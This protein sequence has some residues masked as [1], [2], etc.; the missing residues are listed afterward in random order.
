MRAFVSCT[1]LAMTAMTGLGCERGPHGVTMEHAAIPGRT[2]RVA[3]AS[4]PLRVSAANPR[5]FADGS[6]RVIYLTGS[7]TWSNLQDIG[8]TD[9]PPPFDFSRH[10]D[11]LVDHNHNFTRLWVWE[12]ARWS[13]STA[14]DIYFR[15]L[16][17]ARTGPGTA[18]DG[19]AKFDLTR[20]EPSY[21]DRLRDRVIA[22]GAR[23]IYVSVMLF[24]GWS[25]E[26]KA[27]PGNPWLGHPYHADNNVNGVDLDLDGNGTGEELHTLRHPKA[28]ALQEAYVR[29]VVDTLHDLDNVLWEISNESPPNSREWQHHMVEVIRRHEAGRPKQHPIGVTPMDWTTN[30]LVFSSPSAWVSPVAAD[31]YKDDPPAASGHKVVISDTDHL[32]GMG[33]DGT[34]V[35]KTF[36]RGLNPIYMDD[37]GE[38]TSKAAK[39]DAR[40]AMGDTLAYANRIDLGAMVPR[41]DLVS[42]TYCLANPGV[43][44]LVYVPVDRPLPAVR[45]LW[46]LRGLWT[47]VRG[48]FRQTV[49]VDLTAVQGSV[50]VEWFDPAARRVTRGE[51]VSGGARRSFTAPF[52]G[53]A[54]LYLRSER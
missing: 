35:W 9:P 40:R 4:G 32:W 19:G 5:Y 10:L 6:G 13:A 43:E 26:K 17:Y 54:V 27:R 22:A 42:T 2:T 51:A 11:F 41:G 52:R 8:P 24:Q 48:L 16:P 38:D 15:P 1:M 49:T 25:V 44:Y 50:E 29:K 23:G 3:P 18:R 7:H 47:K 20:F 30:A 21:F 28:L 12:Q 45:G 39:E 46:R 37:L 53:D 34:W 31:G 14:E 33:G 36:T